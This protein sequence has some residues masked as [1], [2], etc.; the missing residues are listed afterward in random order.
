MTAPVEIDCQTVKSRLDTGNDILLLDCRELDEHEIARIAGN[1]LIPMSELQDRLAE[2]N[3]HRDRDVIVYCHH[4]VRSL[5]VVHWLRRNGFLEAQSMRGGID[6][7]SLQID[8]A[9][10]RY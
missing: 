6:Q 5:R 7:W 10:P 4:G 8:T 9:V 2:L 3:E 1:I